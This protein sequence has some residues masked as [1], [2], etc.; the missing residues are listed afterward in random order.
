MFNQVAVALIKNNGAAPSLKY[1]KDLD[2]HNCSK[3]NNFG[4]RG[5]GES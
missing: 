5:S 2:E 3:E 1:K 4:D